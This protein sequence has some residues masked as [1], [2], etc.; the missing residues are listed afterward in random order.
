MEDERLGVAGLERVRARKALRE[1]HAADV[2]AGVERQPGGVADDDLRRAA[3]EIH[4]DRRLE[5]RT[6]CRDA[7]EREQRLLLA[8]EQAR[9][10]AEAPFDAVQELGPVACVADG[11]RGVG[12]GPLGPVVVDD[13]GGLE[14]GID[15]SDRVREQLR[16]RRRRAR[17]AS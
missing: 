6:A 13:S 2:E 11:A 1:P 9:R 12:E 8:G 17:R 3:P 14:A 10:E 16:G 5:E 4:D 7:A 15:S